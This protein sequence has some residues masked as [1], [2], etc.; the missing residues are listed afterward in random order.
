M[1]EEQSMENLI[2][3]QHFG[4]WVSFLVPP[5]FRKSEFEDY[6]ALVEHATFIGILKYVNS[7]KKGVEPRCLYLYAPMSGAGKTGLAVCT[8]KFLIRND[9]FPVTIN[10]TN[11]SF[12]NFM[13]LVMDARRAYNATSD[14][15]ESKMVKD[16]LCSDVVVIDGFGVQKMTEFGTDFILWLVNRFW[17][18]GRRIIFTSNYSI[19]DL[20]NRFSYAGENVVVDSIVSRL[21]TIC[22]VVEVL[23]KEDGR[24]RKQT[25]IT[26]SL[27]DKRFPF[28]E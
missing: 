25:M 27:I 9:Y 17:E 23:T 3:G 4:Q 8:V 10:S 6:I 15:E 28:S 1:S 21:E 11:Y 22:Q 20:K 5:V 24:A 13:D 14:Y 7:I 18:Y 2:T 26:E 12:V 16:C 19:P